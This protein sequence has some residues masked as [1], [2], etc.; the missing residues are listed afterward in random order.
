[1]ALASKQVLHFEKVLAGSLLDS[2]R[3]TKIGQ[4]IRGTGIED[5]EWVHLVTQQRIQVDRFVEL[6]VLPNDAQKE[7][8]RELIDSHHAG[9][10][11]VI[12]QFSRR[13]TG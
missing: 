1:M 7:L 4:T 3:R 10:I 11:A 5:R 13:D 8:R 12:E 2:K 6:I 9:N